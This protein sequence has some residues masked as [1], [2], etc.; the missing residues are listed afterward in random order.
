MFLLFAFVYIC[1]HE[2][3]L[4]V[5]GCEVVEVLGP[6]NGTLAYTDTELRITEVR[7]SAIPRRQAN[8]SLRRGHP[9]GWSSVLGGSFFVGVGVGALVT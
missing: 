8:E 4:C 7:I 6:Y 2:I 9:R 1:I 5:R 3:V